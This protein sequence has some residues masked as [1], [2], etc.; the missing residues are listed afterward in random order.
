QQGLR[1]L[2]VDVDEPLVAMT[3][4]DPMEEICQWVQRVKQ[5]YQVVLL[6]NNV[7]HERIRRIAEALDV[8]FF[9][10]AGKPSRRKLRQA[11]ATMALPAET[12]A[13]VGDRLFTDVLAGNRLGL[14]TVLVDPVLE[15]GRLN[16]KQVLRS[17]EIWI[18]TQLGV[19][20]QISPP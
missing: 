4:A 2:I 14:V 5:D 9:T 7:H 10:A 16:P 11:L 18:S 15:L 3:D 17:L 20:L 1:G 6:S 12:V 8:P 19:I 13:M